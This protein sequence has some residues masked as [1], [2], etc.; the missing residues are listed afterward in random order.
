M[1]DGP[2]P[3]GDAPRPRARGARRLAGAGVEV[4]LAAIEDGVVEDEEQED[5]AGIIF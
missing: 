5:D 2:R 1:A 4:E 3:L